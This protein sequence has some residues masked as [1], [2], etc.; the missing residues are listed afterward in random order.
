M[1]AQSYVQQA[2]QDFIKTIEHLKTDL[3]A[4]QIGRASASLIENLKVE[5]YGTVQALKAV[6]GI[7]IPDAKTIQI[8][9]WDRSIISNIEKA[10]Q[11][12]DLNL[13]PIND[14]AL[15]RIIIPPLT[16]ERRQELGK[17]VRKLAEEAKISIRNTRQHVYQKVKDQEKE[18]AI[19]EDELHM[20]EKEIQNKVDDSNKEIDEIAK[21][22]EEDIYKI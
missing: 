17:V 4:L 22:K 20:A 11:L 16:T 15:L 10:I 18:K 1:S 2:K 12:A 13:N 21:K 5:A 9:P 7:S 14:G 3:V 6:A 19:T 8:Q